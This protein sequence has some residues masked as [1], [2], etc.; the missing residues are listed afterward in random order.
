MSKAIVIF[1]STT[2]NC[3]NMAEII[4]AKLKSAGWDVTIKNVVD[5]SAAE[6]ADYDLILLGS[7]TWGDG[8]LQDDF[9]DFELALSNVD[10]AGKK[11][12][13]FGCGET[14]WPEFCAAVDIIEE[15]VKGCGATLTTEGLKVD[16]D[17]IEDEVSAWAEKAI[18]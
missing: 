2:G 17:I 4:E 16:G 15:R 9:I 10:L 12:A 8:E 11:A 3:E 5:A 18:A 14:S 6:V 7:S 1:G 13:V